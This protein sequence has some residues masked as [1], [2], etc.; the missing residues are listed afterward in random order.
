MSDAFR[1]SASLPVCRAD[2]LPP[3]VCPTLVHFTSFFPFPLSNACW[4]DYRLRLDDTLPLLTRFHYIVSS[5]LLSTFPPP[6]NPDPVSRPALPLAHFT[7]ISPS[8]LSPFHG[9][10]PQHKPRH[11]SLLIDC[12]SWPWYGSNTLRRMGHKKVLPSPLGQL[13]ATYYSLSASS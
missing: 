9:L 12:A 4:Q 5:P 2:S 11:A 13:V 7:Q 8:F 6:L 3:R 1:S 10:P